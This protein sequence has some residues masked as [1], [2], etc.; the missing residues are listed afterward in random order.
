MAFI[1]ATAQHKLRLTVLVSLCVF[2]LTGC[3]QQLAQRSQNNWLSQNQSQTLFKASLDGIEGPLQGNVTTELSGYLESGAIGEL[4]GLAPSISNPGV[5]WAINDSGNRAELFALDRTGRHI[6]T[7]RLPAL[8]VDWEDLASFHADGK[9]WLAIADTGDNLR[10]RS[11]AALHILQEPVLH[12]PGLHQPKAKEA[13]STDPVSPEPVRFAHH[14]TS[15][16]GSVSEAV[17]EP[18]IAAATSAATISTAVSNAASNTVSVAAKTTTLAVHST[19]RFGYEDGPQNVESIAV[20]SADQSIYLVAKRGPQS[21][22]YRLPL[23][24]ETPAEPLMAEQLGKTTGL[25]WAEDDS[26]LE[27]RLGTHFLLGP[28]AMDISV[29]DQLAVIANYRHLYLYRKRQGQSW[30]EA[31]RGEPRM[32][33]SHRMAQSES[34]A[35]S[36]NADYILVGSEGL[37]APVLLV[38]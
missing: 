3:T 4:S 22:I 14:Y 11:E 24:L 17:A 34:V 8:N 37:H 28:T 20:S 21:A 18:E 12:S 27:K 2:L 25:R 19:I 23:T 36:A 6:K 16:N 9:S 15:Q 7:F 33:S 26:W 29:D 35:F 30:A 5:F 1:S 38:R 31:L 32:I 13:E 10:R